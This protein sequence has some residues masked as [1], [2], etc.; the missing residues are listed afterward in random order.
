M[1]Y[2]NRDGYLG[3]DRIQP[4]KPT[5]PEALAFSIA[6]R[7]AKLQGHANG[8]VAI[9]SLHAFIDL[10]RVL[11]R[12]HSD[13]FVE[14][15]SYPVGVWGAESAICHG[16]R[17]F[18]FPHHDIEGLESIIRRRRRSGRRAIVLADGVCTGCG[19]VP[20]LDQYADVIRRVEGLLVIDDAQGFGLLGATPTQESLYGRGGGG[21]MK[22]LG[23]SSEHIIT[24]ASLA[25]TFGVSIAVVS[26]TVELIK[27]IKAF[28]RTSTHCT[29]P[30]PAVLQ[31]A[32]G[33]LTSNQIS[34]DL[35]RF[36][37]LKNV[38]DFRALAESAG[39]R[40]YGG[41]FPIQT[42]FVPNVERAQRRCTRAGIK[43]MFTSQD[44]NRLAI[45]FIV[46]TRH[47]KR[48]LEKAAR[49]IVRLSN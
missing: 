13:V 15:G 10:F 7:V 44:E 17:I 23:L 26:A 45:S 34:G 27:E 5:A 14:Q 29:S 32:T 35:Q 31:T 9:T 16:L 37:L 39:I 40:P 18:S 4:Q 49:L 24:V 36:Q 6:S 48:D 19:R 42:I 1:L 47:S 43:P 8:I 46:S 20:P 11:S 38:Q 33:M 22:Y 28:G 12:R 25:K 21:V 30:R 2:F 41:I 3:L